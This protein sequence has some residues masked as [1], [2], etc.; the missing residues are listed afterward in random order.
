VDK[1]P[2]ALSRHPPDDPGKQARNRRDVV[3]LRP[4]APPPAPE[5]ARPAPGPGGLHAVA[6]A[7]MALCA[8][9]AILSGIAFLTVG[10]P[11]QSGR[12]VIAIGMG[13]VIGFLACV[14][15]AVLTA[16]RDTYARPERPRHDRGS[17][18]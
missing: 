14:S 9:I 6:T 18:P 13:G 1:G 5:P 15:V 4:D 10:W 17:R 16:A 3:P 7:G 11:G 8:L 12:V 2:I